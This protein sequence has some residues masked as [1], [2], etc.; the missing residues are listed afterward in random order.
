MFSALKILLAGRNE[1]RFIVF[2]PLR[3][4]WNNPIVNFE[5]F[6]KKKFLPSE[7]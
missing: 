2:L 6:T 7:M 1:T 3:Y 5:I 4:W